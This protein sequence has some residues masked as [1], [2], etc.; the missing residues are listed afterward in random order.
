M[1]PNSLLVCGVCHLS[2][3]LVTS[4]AAASEIRTPPVSAGGSVPDAVVLREDIAPGD[5]IPIP[6]GVEIQRHYY[7]IRTGESYP[8][9]TPR[10]G[11]SA[12]SGFAP[13]LTG[14][15]CQP[16]TGLCTVESA[17]DCEALGRVYQGDGT[18]CDPN[19]CP[20]LVYSN[21]GGS[22]GFPPGA[23]RLIADDLT[24]V[25]VG[26]CAVNAY[27]ILV[28]GFGDGT[29][30]GF[31]ADF[32]IYDACPGEGG[33]LVPGTE[34]TIA[35]PN[36]GTHLI[37]VDMTGNEVDLAN[38]FWIGVM[39]DQSV[40]GWIMGAPAEIGFTGDVYDSPFL[41]CVARFGGSGLYAGFYAQVYCNDDPLTEFPAY[42]NGE[43]D[44]LILAPGSGQWMAD[45]IELI[46]DDCELSSVEVAVSG[47]S[48]FT[49]D[50]ELWQYCDPGSVISGTEREYQGRGDGSVEIARFVFEPGTVMLSRD[51]LWIAWR[52]S[53]SSTGPIISGE[54]TVG[55]TDDV[56][57]LVQGQSACLYFWFG[58]DPYAGF[59]A[60]IRCLGAVPTGAC[61]EDDV[62]RVVPGI[63]CT[64]PAARWIRDAPCDPDPFDPPCGAYACC[65][66]EPWPYGSCENLV[67]SD[68]EIAGGL[69][70]ADQYCGLEGQDCGRSACHASPGQCC[71]QHE[72]VGCEDRFCCNTVC[73]M[74]VWC[75][76][77][78]WDAVCVEEARQ[79]CDY[80]C[81][82]GQVTW[83][84]PPDGVIDAR[85]PHP[86]NDATAAQ[87]IG[88]F[89]VAAPGPAGPCC[90]SLCETDEGTSPNFIASL[91][92]H[93]AWT[94]AITLGRPITPAAVTTLTYHGGNSTGTFTAHPA[95]A[96]ADASSG[97]AD[98]LT[99]IDCCLN[100]GC[101]PPWGDYSCDIDH[102]GD[103]APSDILRLIDLLNGAGSF[104]PW[105]DTLL[106][107]NAGVCPQP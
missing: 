36:N 35:L 6:E 72:S 75:C 84:D 9:T 60:A 38:H 93:E 13:N 104:D 28:T 70:E 98:V 107:T 77:M 59:N 83:L 23:N 56:Y 33:Q 58:G 85:Q 15:C 87:G 97:P 34:G 46:V 10:A 90:W 27:D 53:N 106:P 101:D 8:I 55:F 76:D 51:W 95:N 26:G 49:M 2:L 99:L 12:G 69:W 19:K 21:I 74:D 41:R 37:Q 52:F 7:N 4:V 79:L 88:T 20:K 105:I 40:A 5:L 18:T 42:Y 24:T 1:L 65:L 71:I 11:D 14:A 29:G 45:D 80:T 78:V 91:E 50:V 62:C 43:L 48:P 94:Y 31:T 100:D 73:D 39:F 96:D 16:D 68:C 67:E 3:A 25:A 82:A 102:S 89:Q 61:C 44:A 103:A 57:A 47:A 54:A 81:P 66:A 32:G 92:E 86:V 22:V 30:P 17:V 64:S 63:E